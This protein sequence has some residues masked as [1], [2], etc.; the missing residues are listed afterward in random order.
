MIYLGVL[1]TMI[2]CLNKEMV[3]IFFLQIEK[4]IFCPLPM[5]VEVSHKVVRISV[6][7]CSSTYY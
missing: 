4:P 5:P 7:E 2:S 1:F 3:I 6:G